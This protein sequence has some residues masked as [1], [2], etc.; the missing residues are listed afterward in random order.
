[1][2]DCGVRRVW[3][4]QRETLVV[5]VDLKQDFVALDRDP[6]EVMLAIGIIVGIE[7]IIA[8]Q[9]REDLALSLGPERRNRSRDHDAAAAE[10]G[11]QGIVEGP[12]AVGLR[13][14]AAAMVGHG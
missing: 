4:M 7:L 8:P 10:A 13:I 2:G 14:G 3:R 5:I 12:N 9:R 1:M 11:A 6:A